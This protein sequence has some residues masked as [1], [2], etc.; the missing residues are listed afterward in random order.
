MNYTIHYAAGDH[1]EPAKV[2]LVWNENNPL[3]PRKGETIVFRNYNEQIRR[4]Y[5]VTHVE[6]ETCIP[7]GKTDPINL[8]ADV[9]TKLIKTETIG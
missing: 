3:M 2:Q 1:G 7:Q 9:Y 8:R 4:T 5:E 6:W